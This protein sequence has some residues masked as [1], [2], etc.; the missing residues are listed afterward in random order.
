LV[1]FRPNHQYQSTGNPM[2]AINPVT[3][4]SKDGDIAVITL[5]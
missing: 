1:T 4:L 3:D 5:N 2:T